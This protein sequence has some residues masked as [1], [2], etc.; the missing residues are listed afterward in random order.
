M[1]SKENYLLVSK[2]G[3]HFSN[4]SSGIP[5]D[6]IKLYNYGIISGYNGDLFLDKISTREEMVAMINN[7]LN[8]KLGVQLSAH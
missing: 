8:F 7:Y 5:E 2:G 4:V 3:K 6:I 1:L